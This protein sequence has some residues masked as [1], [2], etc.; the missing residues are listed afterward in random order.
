MQS[1]NG[2][3]NGTEGRGRDFT[4]GT[5]D[6]VNGLGC[7]KG[8]DLP[9]VVGFKER[10]CLQAAAQH[11]HVGHAVD[12]QVPQAFAE[13]PVVQTI[14][15]AA[16]HT[17]FQIFQIVGQIVFTGVDTD[18]DDGLHQV[19]SG[20]ERSKGVLKGFNDG[21]VMGLLDLPEGNGPNA[22]FIPA[23]FGIGKVKIVFQVEV[24][25]LFVKDGNPLAARL[26]PASKTPV[27]ALRGEY[28]GHI[29]AL[30]MDQE[31]LIKGQAKVLAGGF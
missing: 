11:E 14:E 31:L 9:E 1:A 7:V 25:A 20:F 28:G 3:G 12:H 17:L 10:L 16:C 6:D 18:A 29:G 4:G 27:P 26:H 19:V 8:G 22:A 30:G 5:A 24:I 21:R 13:V 2:F 23:L 15:V